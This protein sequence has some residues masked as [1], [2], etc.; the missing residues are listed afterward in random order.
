M[1]DSPIDATTETG[2]APWRRQS[3]SASEWVFH[4]VI[5]WAATPERVG[6]V[7]ALSKAA[8]VGRGPARG[9]D[10]APRLR[11]VRQ[12][13]GV[14]HP[15][16][17]LAPDRLSRVHL[18]VTPHG[19]QGISIERLGKGAVTHNGLESDEFVAR[20][21]D[22][23]AIADAVTFLV[24]RRPKVMPEAWGAE[25]FRELPFGDADRFGNV[26]E[27]P[28][29]WELRGQLTSLARGTDAILISGA[30]GVG[31]EL[32]ARAL[33]GLS[34]AHEG[35]L[36]SRNAA[37]LPP[38]LIDAE[39]F[40]TQRNYPN[41]GSPE[42]PGLVGEAEGGTLFLDEIGELPLEQQSH[43]LRFLDHGEYQRLGDPRVRTSKV[44]FLAATNRELSSLKHDLLARF[45]RRIVVPGLE[46]RLSDIGLLISAIVREAA[47]EVR[48]YDRFLERVPTEAG[49]FTEHA[50]VHPSLVERLLAQ[51]YTLHF[52]E[53][54][55][56][57]LLGLETSPG[58]RLVETVTLAA[59][60]KA[61]PVRKDIGV[62][63][64]ERVLAASGGNVTQ[65]ARALNLPSRYA[66]YRLIKRLGVDAG[67]H[68]EHS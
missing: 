16:P 41:A 18:L 22:V 6:E 60:L 10:P 64:V 56:L 31:K 11:F 28:A 51:D 44:R 57:V 47:F 5:V 24:E 27:S 36:V 59:E 48:E 68:S 19:Q 52:R 40:G 2:E 12:R 38:S 50:R 34:N 62:A 30:S 9:D 55:R 37:T 4:L 7:A 25:A 1:H 49:S 65:A 17:L 29:S 15:T 53:L 61:L 32:V 26:G 39:L 23:I 58:D 21:G 20:D 66:L 45:A 35:R 67:Q 63:D 8:I 13:P 33:H 42:R 3:A 43:L 46:A 54:R 14:N